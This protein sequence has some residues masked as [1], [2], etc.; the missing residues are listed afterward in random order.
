M[1]SSKGGGRTSTELE[2]R[3]V[4]DGF[5]SALLDLCRGRDVL[6]DAVHLER[7]ELLGDLGELQLHVHVHL[8][9]VA[10]RVQHEL[11]VVDVCTY[12]GHA[13]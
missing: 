3:V 2:A 11:Q 4:V 13:Q 5:L 12:A 10:D 1:R 6:V 8:L 9:D 7:A